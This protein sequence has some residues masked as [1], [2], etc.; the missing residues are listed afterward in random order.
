[1]NEALL[2][3]LL[4]Q[5]VLLS[6]AVGLLSIARPLLKRL[7]AGAAYAA[8]LLVPALMLTPVLPRPAQEPLPVVLQATG[9]PTPAALPALSAPTASVAALWLAPWL[10]GALLVIAVQARR[11]W[12]LARLGTR[13]PAG[14]SPA[15]VG[16][17]RPRIALPADFEQRFAPA[18]RELILAHEQVHRDRLDNFW[19][20]LAC[21][22]TAL[23]WWNPLA[24]W[25]ARRM[26]A[27]Q[28]L[29]C[30]AAVLASRPG[31]VADYTRALLAAHNLT[32]NG[33]PLAS[34]WG[35]THPLVERIAML[36]HP[37]TLTRRRVAS[38]GLGLLSA[39]G[40]AWAAQTAPAISPSTQHA[41]IQTEI[42]IGD[43][44]SKPG[45]ITVLGVPATFGIDHGDGSGHW[46]IAMT[47]TQQADGQLLV[48]T[49]RSY[50]NPLTKLGGDHDQVGAAGTPIELNWPAPDGG[51]AFVM[52]RVVT[53]LPDAVKVTAAGADYDGKSGI[54]R[55]HGPT[56]ITPLPSPRS[57]PSTRAA[58]ARQ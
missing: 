54:L 18:E 16:L 17:L 4:R 15:L 38:L 2:A 36:K 35:T 10:G 55:L 13:L 52:R 9:T 39:A 20:L 29:A 19:N 14:T 1:M 33:A 25:A 42:R 12:R 41:Y 56:E 27:D 48:H 46:E 45:L 3:A 24:W 44:V 40:L 34:R 6:F 5:A 8:W 31:A 37:R 57:P 49:E 47:V 32:P 23:H 11:Q 53:L 58:P 51:P 22:L 43:H 26:R 21:T 30:D 50:G 7:G 28:E